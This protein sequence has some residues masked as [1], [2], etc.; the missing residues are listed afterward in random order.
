MKT[1][2]TQFDADKTAIIV[3]E[4]STTEEKPLNSDSMKEIPWAELQELEAPTWKEQN[5]FEGRKPKLNE[6][7]PS[8]SSCPGQRFFGVTTQKLIYSPRCQVISQDGSRAWHHYSCGTGFAVMES[9]RLME[10]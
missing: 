6:F 7:P 9:V 1:D 3:K 8:W 5:A 4:I 10:S 2:I